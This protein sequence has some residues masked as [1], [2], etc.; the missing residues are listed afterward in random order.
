MPVSDQCREWNVDTGACSS[1]YTGYTLS[2]GQCVRDA[3]FG[4]NPSNPNCK[5]FSNGRC[6]ECP[7]RAYFDANGICQFVNGQ[8][9]TWDLQ[10]GHCLTCYNGYNLDNGA[11]VQAPLADPS[12]SDVGCKVWEGAVCL[13]CSL[14]WVFNAQGVC[15][16]VSDI[17][18]T[19]DN[20][21]QCLTCY[22][23]FNLQNGQCEFV[24]NTQSPPDRGCAE[25]DWANLV[26]KKCSNNWVSVNG[27]CV[28]VSD[29]CR[30]HDANGACTA[31]YRGYAVDN[32]QC[33]LAPAMPAA[34]TMLGCKIWNWDTQVCQECS[35]YWH[36]NADGV[37]VPVSDLCATY[38]PAN[39]QCLTCFG[40]YQINQGICALVP[41][42]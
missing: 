33:V 29:Q 40:G 4:S 10:D 8:C 2:N 41:P 31:C 14:R 5:D 16:P 22:Q 6:N 28:A 11:C 37:C 20:N 30:T 19:W 18:R 1:C 23:G 24:P 42:Q 36:F 27:V 7:F 39:G 34:P 21:G 38:D 26:C 35:K 25:W 9:Q 13:E 3:A 32:G 15:I 17:C 12:V